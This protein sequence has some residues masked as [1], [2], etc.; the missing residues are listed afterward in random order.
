MAGLF[1]FSSVRTRWLRGRSAGRPVAGLTAPNCVRLAL[2]L[3]ATRGASNSKAFR[4]ALRACRRVTFVDCN[5]SNQKCALQAAEV[6]GAGRKGGV[7]WCQVGVFAMPLMLAPYR[8]AWIRW[9]SYRSCEMLGSG[10][11]FND[12]VLVVW[13][14]ATSA[15]YPMFCTGV[16]PKPRPSM[17]TDFETPAPF[18]HGH[19]I[20]TSCNTPRHATGSTRIGTAQAFKQ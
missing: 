19:R 8:F 11:G 4:L 17:R 13:V 20:E 16:N 15:A 10:G 9:G 12:P 1:F 7:V 18:R 2:A 5:K 3:S 6:L 14:A